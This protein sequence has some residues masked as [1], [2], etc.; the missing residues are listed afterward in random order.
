MS[1]D[2]DE[3]DFQ[4]RS[5]TADYSQYTQ[6]VKIDEAELPVRATGA[7]DLARQSSS[8]SDDRKGAFTSTLLNPITS[9]IRNQNPHN[10][11]IAL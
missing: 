2:E 6:R 7:F 5:S 11:G 9:I 1:D 10:Q 8:D 4:N 3:D